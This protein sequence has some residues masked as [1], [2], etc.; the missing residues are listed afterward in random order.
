M[1]GIDAVVIEKQTRD[2]VLSRIR[3][4]VLEWGTVE[5]LRAA[6]LGNRMDIEGLVHDGCFLS[7]RSRLTRIDFKALTGKSVMVYGQTEITRDLYKSMENTPDSL[8]NS[9]GDVEIKNIDSNSPRVKFVHKGVESRIDCDF[10]IGCDGFHGVSR[11]SIPARFRKEFVRNYP[12]GWLG[13][14]SE[15]KPVN[16]EL[17]YSRSE[18][19]F[20]LASM[21][22]PMLS[23]YYIQ[24]PA[25]ERGRELAY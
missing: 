14:L 23:R 18:R 12:F 8:I 11:S 21:R 10:V 16:H 5:Q 7:N 13:V 15:T 17:I 20:A 3:A 1:A 24:V 19:G 25:N 22:N 2:Y 4:G 6:G 9:A